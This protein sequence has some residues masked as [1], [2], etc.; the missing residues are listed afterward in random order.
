[1]YF[2]LT[3]SLEVGEFAFLCP[4]WQNMITFGVHQSS[5]IAAKNEENR[6]SGVFEYVCQCMV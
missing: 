3:L 6:R 5:P 2:L 1:M 4:F